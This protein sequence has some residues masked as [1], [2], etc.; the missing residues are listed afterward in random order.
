MMDANHLF[1]NVNQLFCNICKSSHYAI[2]LKLNIL[3]CV[4]YIL[5]KLKEIRVSSFSLSTLSQLFALN[6]TSPAN[7]M[8]FS[9]L[10]SPAQVSLFLFPT[11][12]M[13]P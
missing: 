11:T 13:S 9:F 5:I 12:S 2:H 10:F 8:G 1:Y 7:S 4:H 3:L 6:P